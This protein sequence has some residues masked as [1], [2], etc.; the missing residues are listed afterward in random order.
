MPLGFR[1]SELLTAFIDLSDVVV[2]LI[3]LSD[4]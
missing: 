1:Y 3:K 4:R 2:R